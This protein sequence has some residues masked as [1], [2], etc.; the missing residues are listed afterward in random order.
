MTGRHGSG[1]PRIHGK[2][3]ATPQGSRAEADAEA[4]AGPPPGGN[5]KTLDLRRRTR[6]DAS[7]LAVVAHPVGSECRSSPV[8]ELD[9]TLIIL[10]FFLFATFLLTLLFFRPLDRLAWVRACVAC[11]HAL[12]HLVGK[13]PTSPICN[14]PDTRTVAPTTDWHAGCYPLLA[15]TGCHLLSNGQ[16]LCRYFCCPTWTA[17]TPPLPPPHALFSPAG[18][19]LAPTPNQNLTPHLNSLW[20]TITNTTPPLTTSMQ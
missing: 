19:L 17:L 11:P 5:I 2:H 9:C 7:I 3:D 16:L 20:H 4:D 1:R 12:P 18:L 13:T 8:S 15:L 6:G 14:P 10:S